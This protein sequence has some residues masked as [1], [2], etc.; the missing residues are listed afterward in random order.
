MK[1]NARDQC[2]DAITHIRELGLKAGKE[3][4]AVIRTASATVGG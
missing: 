2:Q 4:C 1:S 3:A